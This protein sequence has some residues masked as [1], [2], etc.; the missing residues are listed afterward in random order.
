LRD[1]APPGVDSR[2]LFSSCSIQPT[3]QAAL[4]EAQRRLQEEQAR[5]A[6]E[7]RLRQQAADEAAVRVSV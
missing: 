5:Q 7:R 1:Q 3:P 6:E 4:L 2:H